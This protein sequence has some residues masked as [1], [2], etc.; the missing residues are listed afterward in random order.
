MVIT[1]DAE[2][3]ERAERTIRLRDGLVVARGRHA[4]AR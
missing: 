1:H 4:V 2:V 3:A